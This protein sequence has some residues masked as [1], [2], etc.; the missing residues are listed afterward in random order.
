MAILK[1]E[2]RT[3]RPLLA[4][5]EYMVDFNKTGKYGVFGIG[6]D[7]LYAVQQMEF[8]QRIFYKE[9]LLHSYIQ[10]IFSFDSGIDLGILTIRKICKEIAYILVSDE[11]QIFGAIHFNGTPNIH[12]HYMINYVSV[13]GEMYRQGH[14][15]NYYKQLINSI[16]VN[17]GL[18]PIIYYGMDVLPFKIAG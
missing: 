9:N 3:P 15:V 5:Y 12:C 6:V 7:P 16:L 13:R 14:S 10:I 1:F 4:M 17:Y 8:I 18:E 2:N 11:R